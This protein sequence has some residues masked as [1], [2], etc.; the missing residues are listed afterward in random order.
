[1]FAAGSAAM[2]L[3]FDIAVEAVAE[4][5]DWHTHEHIPERLQIPGFLRGSRWLAR[6]G[7]PRYLVLY[8]VASIDVLASRPYLARLNNPSPWTARMMKHYV[9][10]RRALCNVV[11]GAGSGCGGVAMLARFKPVA[12]AASDLNDWVE[13]AVLPTLP[14]RRGLASAH[15]L[16]STL[17]AQMTME[18]RIRGKDHDLHSALIATG[19]D[20]GTIGS[21]VD[22]ELQAGAFIAHGASDSEFACGIYDQV[23]SL[24]AEERLDAP[25]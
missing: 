11:A 19:Y 4:H 6:S 15:L 12:G 17:A 8:E 22:G 5:D 16:V 10:M 18:Q 24:A 20:A 21:L 13:R 9:G 14:G 23:Y 1:M 25:S 7:A 2:V 3:S